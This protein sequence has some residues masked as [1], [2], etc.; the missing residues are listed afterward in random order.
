MTDRAVTPPS[1]IRT[2][3]GERWL[4]LLLIAVVVVFVAQNRGPVSIALLAVSISAPLWL[5]L[6]IT[7]LIGLV[8]GVARTRRTRRR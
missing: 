4:S 3:L 6:S 2:F 5:T 7:F 1:R 8:A